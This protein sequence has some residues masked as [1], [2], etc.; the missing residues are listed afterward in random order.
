[1]SMLENKPK[2]YNDG[3]TKQSFKDTCD[4]NRILK[5]AQKSGAISHLAKHGAQYGDFSDFNFMEAQVQLAK[6]KEIFDDLPSE[7]RR[8][9]DQDPAQFFEY[10]N[11]PENVERLETLLPALAEPGTMMMSPRRNA[12]T[13]AAK[14]KEIEPAKEP[15]KEIPEKPEK[16][17]TD[18][19]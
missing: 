7:I 9:F 8:E 6:A 11:D 2:K 16:E 19:K 5:K 10:A 12:A 3:R 18:P 13:E 1:M 14:D 15:E 17:G 4:I